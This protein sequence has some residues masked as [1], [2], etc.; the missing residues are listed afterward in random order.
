MAQTTAADWFLTD[1]AG[2]RLVAVSLGL[3]AHGSLG[4]VLW[5]V[6]HRLLSQEQGLAALQGLRGTSLWIS[7]RIFHQAEDAIREMCRRD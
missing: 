2:A 4:V 5:N 6:A 7:D 1:D 3:E